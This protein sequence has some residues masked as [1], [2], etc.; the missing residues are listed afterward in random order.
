MGL[1]HGIAGNGY[2]FLHLYQA[3]NDGKYL[4]RAAEFEQVGKKWEQLVR[5]KEMRLADHPFSLFEGLSGFVCFQ[6]DLLRALHDQDII[7]FPC[8]ADI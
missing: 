5:L 8:F 1:C 7:G 4:N 3:T 2:L 6:H